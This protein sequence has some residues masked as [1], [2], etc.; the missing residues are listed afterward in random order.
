MQFSQR[1]E[2]IKK[3]RR[4]TNKEIGALCGVSE[5]AVRSWISGSKVPAADRVVALAD[6]LGVSLD[7]LYGKN[8]KKERPAALHDK[9]LSDLMNEVKDFDEEDMRRMIDQACLI[10]AAKRNVSRQ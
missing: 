2:E 7:Y 10:S 1:L 9:A 3:E 4:M 6:A 5:A 8:A